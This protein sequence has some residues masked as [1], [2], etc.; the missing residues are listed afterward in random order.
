MINKANEEDYMPDKAIPPG[1]TL[2]ENLNYIGM[3]QKEL[4]E[5]MGRPLKTINEIIQGK[6]G[7]TAET[8]IQL[9][10]V[11]GIP[12]KIWSN[13]ERNYRET[14]ARIEDERRIK[15][16]EKYIKSYPYL[17]MVK[18]GWIASAKSNID[19]VKNLLN[20]FGVD[21]LR[22]VSNIESIAFRKAASEKFN[23]YAMAAWLRQGEIIAQGID[24]KE[25]NKKGLISSI[26]EIKSMT[27]ESPQK[28]V[29]KLTRIC[30]QYGIALVILPHLKN[31]YVNGATRWLSPTK[32]I[33]QLSLRYKYNDV[34]WFTFFH[35]LGH[36]ILHNKK[37]YFID[38][39]DKEFIDNLEKEKE[40][41]A[42][43][44]GRL[45]PNREY[46]KF[47]RTK[48]FTAKNVVRFAK[49]LGIAPAI[50]VGRLQHDKVI[51]YSYLNNLRTKFE[52]RFSRT[53]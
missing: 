14:L 33:I 6:K 10:R 18:Y 43:A 44:A 51:P 25:F 13:L 48:L 9:E 24:T 46:N 29:P 11:L 50:V 49:K 21:S 2:L 53:N 36:I 20:F 22:W 37:E 52:F 8:S 45:I 5:R 1:T 38:T 27:K 34:F 4:A 35:E 12:A 42:F 17:E 23:P 15:S 7:I 28:F 16:E 40:A 3:T 41:D 39:N 30:A 32:A 26:K 31:T 19:K 47:I